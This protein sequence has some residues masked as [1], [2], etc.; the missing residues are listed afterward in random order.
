MELYGEYEV[1]RQIPRVATSRVF[2]LIARKGNGP[3]DT[4]FVI[5]VFPLAE[6]AEAVS[7]QATDLDEFSVSGRLAFLES[8][9]QQ[10]LAC[11][12]GARNLALWTRM[13]SPFANS[14]SPSDVATTDGQIV[15][16][17]EL[18]GFVPKTVKHK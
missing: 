8:I 2:P 13:A 4:E 17:F 16:R 15:Y 12:A 1:V 7:P 10:K 9:Q 3:A 5:R 11:D 18:G 6:N 14:V